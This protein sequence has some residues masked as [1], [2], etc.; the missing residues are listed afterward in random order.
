V[1]TLLEPICREGRLAG[2]GTVREYRGALQAAGFTL[3]GAEDVSAQVRRTWSVVLRR[4]LHGLATQRAYRRYLLNRAHRERTFALTVVRLWL[5]YRT[6]SLRYG[7][8][9]ARR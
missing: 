8:L 2:L 1:R 5:A 9:S 6:G 3:E 7:I 4:T